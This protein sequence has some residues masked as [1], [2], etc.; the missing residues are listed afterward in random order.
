M[1]KLG[2]I[3]GDNIDYN[4]PKETKN[5]TMHVS[6]HKKINLE[7]IK[8]TLKI[9]SGKMT[10]KEIMKRRKKKYWRKRDKEM[11]KKSLSLDII[12]LICL[13]EEEELSYIS[14]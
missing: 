8:E 5:G 13:A 7:K 12:P 14:E 11:I 9:F 4:L 6:Q 2:F 1:M 10:L 3:S